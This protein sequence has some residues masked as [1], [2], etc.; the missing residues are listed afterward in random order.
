MLPT[1]APQ[2]VEKGICTGKYKKFRPGEI[3]CTFMGPSAELY[4]FIQKSEFVKFFPSNMTNHP[5]VLGA[6]DQLV[7]VNGVLE[8]DLPARSHRS[9]AVRE[10][11][12]VTA[13]R[14][15]ASSWSLSSSV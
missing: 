15:L 3:N 14:L 11:S 4:E 13:S 2:W 7:G 10:S 1:G 5:T 12:A 9:P 8:I 6:E